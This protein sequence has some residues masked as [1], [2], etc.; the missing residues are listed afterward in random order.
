MNIEF[1]RAITQIAVLPLT[2]AVLAMLGIVGALLLGVLAGVLYGTLDFL[3]YLRAHWAAAFFSGGSLAG[4]ISHRWLSPLENCRL[5]AGQ[6]S[7]NRIAIIIPGTYSL[8]SYEWERWSYFVEGLKKRNYKIFGFQWN[9]VNSELNRCDAADWL[10]NWLTA[11]A[12]GAERCLLIGHSYGGQVAALCAQHPEVTDVVGVAS[13]Y[14]MTKSLSPEQIAHVA[15]AIFTKSVFVGLFTMLV[16]W[17]CIAQWSIDLPNPVSL[18]SAAFVM[19]ILLWIFLILRHRLAK[20][21][22]NRGL[23]VDG[24]PVFC[25]QVHGDI[26]VDQLVAASQSKFAQPQAAPDFLQQRVL[27]SHQFKRVFWFFYSVCLTA[28]VCLGVAGIYSPELQLFSSI[29]KPIWLQLAL[30]AALFYLSLALLS[31]ASKFWS[32][33]I[34]TQKRLLEIV[35][36]V[37]WQAVVVDNRRLIVCL[38]AGIH[39][40]ERLLYAIEISKSLPNFIP[41]TAAI[42]DIRSGARHSKAINDARVASIVFDALD[43]RS[44]DVVSQ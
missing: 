29:N 12:P 25:L 33:I 30:G 4:N 39:P 42:E 18:G 38:L 41:L 37:S 22:A 19:Y 5:L 16:V 28:S 9:S 2:A 40:L 34:P 43:R 35:R 15:L 20:S 27:H 7:A 8:S 11:N 36:L 17:Y 44:G 21:T 24:A 3:R 31:L 26:I 23:P 32:S 10:K 1:E 13:P 6:G 14:V